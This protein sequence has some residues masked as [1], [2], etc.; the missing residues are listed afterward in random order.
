M[1]GS[2]RVAVPTVLHKSRTTD[3]GPAIVLH[4]T[5]QFALYV[6]V[7]CLHFFFCTVDSC[8]MMVLACCI[9][10]Y[11]WVFFKFLY[12]MHNGLNIIGP[13]VGVG[14]GGGRGK[15]RVAG[16]AGAGVTVLHNCAHLKPPSRKQSY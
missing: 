15:G 12:I 8:C 10:T 1:K 2:A 16:V 13:S 11:V 5:L 6:H 14:G 4:L 7:A 9:C 3:H